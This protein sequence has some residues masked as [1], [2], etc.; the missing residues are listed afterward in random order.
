MTLIAY[1][2]WTQGLEEGVQQ[3]EPWNRGKET[4]YGA[5]RR[6][7]GIDQGTDQGGVMMD[8]HEVKPVGL[9]DWL[10]PRITLKTIKQRLQT[11]SQFRGQ[12]G[13]FCF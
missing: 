3:V 7:Q 4:K 2:G 9:G 5:D 10:D 6:E 11:E 8:I 13:E 12:D 1:G